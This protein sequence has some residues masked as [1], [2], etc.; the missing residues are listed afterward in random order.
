MSD[1]ARSQFTSSREA[2]ELL[3]ACII[4]QAERDEI[5]LSE[6][7]RKMLYFSEV[8][9]SPP[10]W[11]ELNQAFEREYNDAE[12]EEKIASLIQHFRQY[13]KAQDPDQWQRWNA[14]ITALQD[15]DHYILVMTSLADGSMAPLNRTTDIGIQRWGKVLLMGMALGLGIVLLLYFSALLHR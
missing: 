6:V 2:K 14:A 15:E 4:A 8:H 12:Y 9:D 11:R 5:A 13:A 3:V 1:P 10:D 7:E